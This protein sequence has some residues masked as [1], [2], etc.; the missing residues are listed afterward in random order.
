MHFLSHLLPRSCLPKTQQLDEVDGV[1]EVSWVQPRIL[2]R[3]QI[4]SL[5]ERLQAWS[6]SV[7]TLVTSIRAD[8]PELLVQ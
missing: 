7:E 4:A 6:E 3:E 5:A 1:V 2:H 8:A